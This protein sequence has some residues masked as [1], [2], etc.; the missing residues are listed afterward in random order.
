MYGRRILH[1][2]V[3]IR[4]PFVLLFLDGPPLGMLLLLLS[5]VLQLQF[6]VLWGLVL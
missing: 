1:T 2:S 3:E 6:E 4:V 5:F